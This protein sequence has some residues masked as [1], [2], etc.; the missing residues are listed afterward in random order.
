[1]ISGCCFWGGFGIFSCV[2]ER[3]WVIYVG[4]GFGVLGYFHGF[5][6]VFLLGFGVWMRCLALGRCFGCL[7]AFAFAWGFSMF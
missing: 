1:M 5:W 4:F 7:F 3:F 2:I 6:V